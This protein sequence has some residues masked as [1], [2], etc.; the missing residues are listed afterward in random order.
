VLGVKD[1]QVL[2]GDGLERSPPMARARSATC[3]AL[4]SCVGVMRSSPSARKV[5]AVSTLA[6]F[7]LKSPMSAASL[8]PLQRLQQPAGAHQDRAVQPQQEVDDALLVGLEHARAGHPRFDARRL[9]LLHRR[10]QPVQFQVI[11]RDAGRAQVER[12]GELFGR[13][14][15]E[16]EGGASCELR[17]ARFAGIWR[18]VAGAH[19]RHGCLG[20]AQFKGGR[21]CLQRGELLDGLAAQLVEQRGRRKGLPLMSAVNSARA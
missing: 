17:V 21:G 18:G 16:V 5:S 1:G 12:G 3:A 14:H 11:Q 13:A 19:C 2:V 20:I 8:R 9:H 10:A 4:R 15:E 7:R 6:A